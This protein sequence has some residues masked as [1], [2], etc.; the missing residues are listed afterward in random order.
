MAKRAA[1]AKTR[2][3]L[4]A[5][6]KRTLDYAEGL[7]VDL[8]GSNPTDDNIAGGLSSIEEKSLGAVKKGGNGPIVEVVGVGE[9]PTRQGTVFADAP[10]GGVENITSLASSG[11]QAIIFSTGI[12]NP[13]GH[14]ISPTLK[15]TGNPRTAENMEENIDVDLRGVIEGTMS[16][17]EATE[18]LMDELLA[19]LSGK[20]TTSE[21]LGETEVTVSRA[22][23]NG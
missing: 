8:I 18:R 6:V 17:E 4:L 23:L 1:D 10:C 2:R 3:K 22:S 19:V 14:P 21:Q 16:Y 11:A 12:G 20:L 7:G 5:C 15:V 13:I 9:R